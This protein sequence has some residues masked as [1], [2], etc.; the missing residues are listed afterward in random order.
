ML[1]AS[2]TDALRGIRAL[3]IDIDGVLV[4]RGHPIAGADAAPR[5]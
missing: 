3:L 2:L 1:D 4:L 5:S